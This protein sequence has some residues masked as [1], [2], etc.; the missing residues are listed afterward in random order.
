MTENPAKVEANAAGGRGR[1][2]RLSAPS[3][4]PV[5][6]SRSRLEFLFDGIFAIAMTI[7]VLDLKVPELEESR[8]ARALLKGL[9]HHGPAF[10][11]YLVSFVIL[12]ILWHNHQRQYR[13]IRRVRR[14]VLAANF[15]LMFTAAAFPFCAALF[16]RYPSNPLSIV[17]YLAALFFH[18]CFA[19]LQWY[20]AQR[21]G[22]LDPD[23]DPTEA[24]KIRRKLIR[25]TVVLGTATALYGILALAK[26]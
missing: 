25:R 1:P 21:V 5:E 4:A 14:P 22:D 15:G 23:L 2:S 18:A 26:L 3:G 8:S 24:R 9:A 11:G 19:D 6:V 16:S 7:L 17:F 13:Y 10:L 20:L 12:G